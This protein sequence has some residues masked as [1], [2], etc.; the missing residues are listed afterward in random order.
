MLARSRFLGLAAVA[1]AALP[2]IVRAQALIPV[3]LSSSNLADSYALP[4]YALDQG[5]FRRAGL[6]VTITSFASS[7]SIANALAGGAVDVAHAD[8]IAVANAFNHGVPW[9]FFA[10]GGLYASDA[11][12]TMLCAPPSSTIRTGKDL[13]GK[14]VGVISLASIST[15][16]VKSW[17]ESNGGS[18]DSVK[19]FELPFA[20]MVPAMQRGDIAAAFIA[21]PFLSQ[22]RK[23]LRVVASAYDAIAKS[24][25]IVATFAGK[26]WLTQNAATARRVASALNEAVRWANTHHD[27]SAVITAK[28]TGLAV[29]TVKAMTRVK[30]AAMDPKLVQPVLDAAYR[31][32]SIEKPVS[33]ADIV[34]SV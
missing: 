31:F 12:T 2:S 11:S 26:S 3:R 20:T 16:G 34:V 32:R 30:Y 29:E 14:S 27:E 25:F 22:T 21:E 19:F 4:Y 24:F 1:P 17:I 10:G 33:A 28:G 15:L 7:G 5:F 6:D 23:E 9:A 18:L 8:P 13:D